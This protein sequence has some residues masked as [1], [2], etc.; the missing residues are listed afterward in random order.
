MTLVLAL[1]LAAGP[2]DL[3][4]QMVD[5]ETR[6]GGAFL[7]ARGGIWAGGG[8]AF[9][10]V[11]QDFMKV[12]LEDDVLPSAG[13]DA[14]VFVADRFMIFGS[15]DAAWA[16]DVEVRALGAAVGFRE[17]RSAGAPAGVPDETTVYVGGLWSTFE[18]D[19]PGFGDFEDAYGF[20]AGLLLTWMPRPG[21][22]LSAMAEY[23]LV[24][25]DYE[26]DVFDGDREAGGST[27]WVGAAL[28]LRF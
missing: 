5:I 22:G 10:A 14:G 15:A 17:K 11:R 27:V 26:E 2:E 13:I 28:D 16:K 12:K 20:R 24:E 21:L 7:R 18:V 4:V 23:R 3:P 25:Y 6:D 19:A 1:A 9:E 8:F